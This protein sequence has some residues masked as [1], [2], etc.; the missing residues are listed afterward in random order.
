MESNASGNGAPAGLFVL[1]LLLDIASV[2]FFA[3]AA[4]ASAMS[5]DAGC[6]QTREM[7]VGASMLACLF[8]P[9]AIAW[10]AWRE[11]K[12]RRRWWVLA[13]CALPPVAIAL[14]WGALLL[15]A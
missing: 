13:V 1:L 4:L 3:M 6:S 8:I 2:P 5:C 11:G 9:L 15:F 10:I 7:L 14:G 12:R